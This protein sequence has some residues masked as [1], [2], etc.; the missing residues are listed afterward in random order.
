MHGMELEVDVEAGQSPDGV[1][2]Q[3]RQVRDLYS[4]LV[5]TDIDLGVIEAGP[6]FIEVQAELEP[7][8]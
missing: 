1:D 7:G 5:Q 6:E 3:L 4:A 2:T 8:E